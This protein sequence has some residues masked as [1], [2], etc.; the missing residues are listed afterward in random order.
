[1]EITVDVTRP[2]CLIG[3]AGPLL[4]CIWRDSPTTVALRALEGVQTRLAIRHGR[5]SSLTVV[6]P[7]GRVGALGAEVEALSVELA[8]GFAEHGVGNAVVIEG[9]GVAAAIAHGHRAR[10]LPHLSCPSESFP[11]VAEALA[12]LARLPGQTPD[13]Y[14]APALATDVELLGRGDEG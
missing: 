14:A 2:E 13:L 4:V 5:I 8:A 10:V 3:H 1:V 11:R 12:W 6:R 7:K 9:T